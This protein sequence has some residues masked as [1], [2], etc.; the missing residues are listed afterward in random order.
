[1]GS[2]DCG[3]DGNVRPEAR[4]A[5]ENIPR[6]SRPSWHCRNQDT[7]SIGQAAANNWLA[8]STCTMQEPPLVALQGARQH[9]HR[10]GRHKS[11]EGT[12]G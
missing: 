7:M 10:T 9:E 4:W 12:T 2:I 3:D 1:M 5:G 8:W 6:Q 11:V